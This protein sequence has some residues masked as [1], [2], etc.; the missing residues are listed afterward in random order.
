MILD[1]CVQVALATLA[2]ITNRSFERRV[3]NCVHR[4]QAATGLQAR[5]IM[6]YRILI[7]QWQLL[8]TH[9]LLMLCGRGIAQWR[10]SCVVADCD[11]KLDQE[12]AIRLAQQLEALNQATTEMAKHVEMKERLQSELDQASASQLR[13]LHRTSLT[14][15]MTLRRVRCRWRQARLAIVVDGWKC[16]M[17]KHQRSHGLSSQLLRVACAKI[18]TDRIQRQLKRWHQ[19]ARAHRL[20][21]KVVFRIQHGFTQEV[22]L[23]ALGSWHRNLEENYHVSHLHEIRKS[24]VVPL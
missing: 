11:T 9:R 16:A 22:L 1:S 21:A 23:F 18:M 17:F 12:R 6:R 13:C 10:S 4:W 5:V 24:E 19:G 8:I 20:G 14:A 2:T 7:N 3:F 15:A